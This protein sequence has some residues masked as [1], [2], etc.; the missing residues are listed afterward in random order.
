MSLLLDNEVDDP[1]HVTVHSDAGYTWPSVE[2]KEVQTVVPIVFYDTV[3]LSQC[4]MSNCRIF[5]WIKNWKEY[6][7][8][9][10]WLNQDI[11]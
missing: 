2:S 11:T 6:G 3:S 7:R 8:K 9:W 4:I 10:S 5:L 1:L